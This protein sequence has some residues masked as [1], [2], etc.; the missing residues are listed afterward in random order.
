MSVGENEDDKNRQLLITVSAMKLLLGRLYTYVYTIAKLS[1]EDVLTVHKRLRETLPNQAL[2][3]SSD[4]AISDV[5][6]DD[7]AHEIDRILRGVE[8]EMAAAA[9]RKTNP[10]APS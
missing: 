9:E 2:V 7:V 8:K 4:P 5:M 6:S 3:H 10:K 1:P